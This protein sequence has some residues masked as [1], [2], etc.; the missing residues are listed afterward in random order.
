MSQPKLDIA[1]EFGPTYEDTGLRLWGVIDFRGKVLDEGQQ[2]AVRA[3]FEA[4]PSC[5]DFTPDI[6][7]KSLMIGVNTD[8]STWPAFEQEVLDAA[9]QNFNV[10]SKVYRDRVLGN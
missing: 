1:L 8:R 3:V 4:L 6:K 10:T 9:H 7:G 2:Q 5:N